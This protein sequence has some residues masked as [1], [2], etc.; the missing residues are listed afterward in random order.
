MICVIN[1]D[2]TITC[3]DGDEFALLMGAVANHL[4]RNWDGKVVDR[5]KQLAELKERLE[6]GAP[7]VVMFAP[8]RAPQA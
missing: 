7:C 4:N 2:G 1:P 3:Y 6:N 5:Q 8:V